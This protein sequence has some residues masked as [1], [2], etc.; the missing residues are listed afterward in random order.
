M[1][2]FFQTCD[3]ASS[4]SNG[5]NCVI[6]APRL[7][8]VIIGFVILA[9]IVALKCCRGRSPAN[10]TVLAQ[11]PGPAPSPWSSPQLMAPPPVYTYQQPA[12]YPNNAFPPPLAGPV[13]SN[14][15]FYI[16]A[17]P[18]ASPHA[19][20]ASSSSSAAI[21][22][23][24]KTTP[25]SAVHCPHHQPVV[26]PNNAFPSPAPVQSGNRLHRHHRSTGTMSPPSAPE[27]PS[28]SSEARH[29]SFQPL[30]GDPHN[31]H[32]IA[33]HSRQQPVVQSDDT[34]PTPTPLQSNNPFRRYLVVE[35]VSPPVSSEVQ[36]ATSQADDPYDAHAEARRQQ[37]AALARYSRTSNQLSESSTSSSEP[38]PPPYTE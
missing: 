13:R 5:E 3:S 2:S 12:I 31:S 20:R 17:S 23:F 21:G 25:K 34:F 32:A 1:S 14:N 36:R 16:T 28:T 7:V 22:D 8:G 10:N 24:F 30:A 29:T 19:R 27:A 33:H 6:N 15:Q 35:T 4:S 18:P 37:A 11:V 9:I 38:R 26:R